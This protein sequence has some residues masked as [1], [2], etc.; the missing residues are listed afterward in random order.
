MVGKGV[1]VRDFL[2]DAFE[3]GRLVW[4]WEK[5]LPQPTYPIF[6]RFVFFRWAGMS[7]PSTKME[8]AACL[9]LRVLRQKDDDISWT[10]MSSSSMLSL[11]CLMIFGDSFFAKPYPPNFKDV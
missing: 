2:A 5:T 6:A 7:V 11:C 4:V 9:A 3:D 10:L 1:S 8:I